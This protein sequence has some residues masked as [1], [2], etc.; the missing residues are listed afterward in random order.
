MMFAQQVS[1]PTG[2]NGGRRGPSAAEVEV[3]RPDRVIAT[4][5]LEPWPHGDRGS[6]VRSAQDLMRLFVGMR[7]VPSNG[8]AM[9]AGPPAASF[10]GPQA[11]LVGR[12]GLGQSP[13]RPAPPALIRSDGVPGAPVPSLPGVTP[14]MILAVATY[15]AALAPA[16]RER[17]LHEFAR[18][19]RGRGV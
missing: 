19:F 7:G 6:F 12:V 4:S 16:D 14:E 8:A 11:V 5:V 18:N 15:F 9:V 2:P 17:V 10:A 1:P 13:G 3:F